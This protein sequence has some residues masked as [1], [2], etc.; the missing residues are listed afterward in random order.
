MQLAPTYGDVVADVTSFL[1]ARADAA[2]ARGVPSVLVDPGIGFGKT[3]AHNLALLR[4]MPLDTPHPVL[5]GASRKGFIGQ[6]AHVPV[7]AD[8]DAASIA[9]HLF[10][11]E[12]GAAMVRAHDVAGHVQALAMAA[13]L[14]DQPADGSAARS[15]A[16]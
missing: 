11:A 13:A 4:A 8:R 12:R 9:V 7:P 16:S 15:S 14:S 1:A 3:V 10:A 5:I 2:L 6:L